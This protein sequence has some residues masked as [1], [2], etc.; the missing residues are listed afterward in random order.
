MSKVLSSKDKGRSNTVAYGLDPELDA[1][2]RLL[3][4]QRRRYVLHS[5]KEYENP[6]ALADLAKEVGIR[7]T[8]GAN[9][10]VSVEE[11]K[12]ISISLYHTHIPK[13]RDANIVQYDK[14]TDI[15]TLS[16]EGVQWE[17]YEERLQVK[18]PDPAK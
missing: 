9:S 11:V 1:I 15:V 16:D 17:E 3:S 12:R 13:L 2:F 4:S 7:E 18:N 14:E 10:E 6:L 8:D 5:L